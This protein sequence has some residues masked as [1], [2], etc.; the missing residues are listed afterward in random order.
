MGSPE[1]IRI[2]ALTKPILAGFATS[3][4]VSYLMHDQSEAIREILAISKLKIFDYQLFW[5]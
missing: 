1:D 4:S 2:V 3:V 5:S